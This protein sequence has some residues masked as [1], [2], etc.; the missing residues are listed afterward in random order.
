[1]QS[2]PARCAVSFGAENLGVIDTASQN[3]TAR[4]RR[5]DSGG[6]C[7]C[8]IRALN[9]ALWWFDR[10]DWKREGQWRGAR[11]APDCTQRCAVLNSYR[12][13]SHAADIV[14]FTGAPP[15]CSTVITAAMPG[16]FPA[17]WSSGP[18]SLHCTIDDLRFFFSFRI[19][20]KVA[21]KRSRILAVP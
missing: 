4:T 21:L 16:S 19:K 6:R 2:S 5:A 9:E 7:H 13:D 8:A 20:S 15:R 10:Y 14:V 18:A 17:K 1:M 12:C 3:V 11:R